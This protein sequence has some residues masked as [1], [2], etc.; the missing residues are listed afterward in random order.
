MYKGIILPMVLYGCEAWSDISEK[1]RLRVFMSKVLRRLFGS[2]GG[3]EVKGGGENC[4]MG[5]FI[6]CTVYR[7]AKYK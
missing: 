6:T 3:G 2:K 7:I 4:I 1:H 5:N